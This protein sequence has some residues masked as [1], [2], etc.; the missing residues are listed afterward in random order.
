MDG[1]GVANRLEMIPVFVALGPGAAAT[2]VV[3]QNLGAGKADRAFAGLGVA[4]TAA[5]VTGGVL[6][7]GLWGA[8]DACLEAL[9]PNAS[10]SV[11]EEGFRYWAWSLPFF[12]GVAV[13]AGGVAGLNGA[14]RFGG[15]LL[16]DL[17]AYGVLLPALSL[18][19][20]SRFGP[21]AYGPPTASFI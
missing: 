4:V 15:P 8:R 21:T 1:V 17:C 10:S 3:G 2:T 18:P 11:R 7:L 12:P 5:V 20:A 16:V 6:A 14:G 9:A 19:A 13:A